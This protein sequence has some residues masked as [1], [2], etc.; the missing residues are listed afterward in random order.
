M[1]IAEMH[2]LF[3]TVGQQMGIQQVRGILPESIDEYLNVAINEKC[4]SVLQQNASTQFKDKLTLQDNSVSPINALSTLYRSDGEQNKNV[5]EDHSEYNLMSL[6]NGNVFEFISFVVGIKVND[7]IKYRP[8]RLIEHDKLYMTLS[9]ECSKA[10]DEYPIVSLFTDSNDNFIAKV[11]ATHPGNTTTLIFNY[12]KKP[13]KVDIGNNVEC[14]LPDFLH[15][16]I[17]EL[18]VQ[19]FFQS[20]GS[21]TKQVQ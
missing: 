16:E 6:H 9:D 1:T 7:S 19:K 13:N 8:C 4:R 3:R 15:T 17:V 21:T 12:I 20:V 11:F 18:A 5:V 14:D 2:I 10:D